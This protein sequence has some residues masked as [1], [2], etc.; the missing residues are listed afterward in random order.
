MI[1]LARVELRRFLSR[2]LTQVLTALLL[3]AIVVTGVIV[4]VH[5]SAPSAGQYRQARLGRASNVA[6][7]IKDPQRYGVQ[8]EPGETQEQ[9]CAR[10][11]G[12]VSNWVVDKRFDLGGLRNIFLGTSFVLAVT[13]LILGASFIG[14]EWH[15]G[16]VTT[17]LTWEPRRTRVLLTKV[18]VCVAA[19]FLLLLLVEIVFGSVLWLDAAT[20]GITTGTGGAAWL[21]SVA[22]VVVRAAALGAFAA[23]VG[24][25]IATVGRNT[26]AALG[27]AFV[28]FAVVERLI[29]GLR[30]MW[31]RWLVGENGA[32][33]LIGTDNADVSM[34]RTMMSSGVVLLAYAILLV[35][36]GLAWFRARDLT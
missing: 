1:R 23:A 10:A 27:A 9:A 2:R 35:A 14:A 36:V 32:V 8:P 11:M 22:G 7:C 5:S 16:T 30:P 6:A 13:G 4:A 34:H 3:V 19:V 26:A 15:W 31:Q 18:V 25:S 33:F 12:P 21:R 17:L 29:R 20:R 28:Y 24:M